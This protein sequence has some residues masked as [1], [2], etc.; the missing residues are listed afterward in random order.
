MKRR[1]NYQ[2][3]IFVGMFNFV[4]SSVIYDV[5]KGVIAGI[6]TTIGTVL[7]HLIFGDPLSDDKSPEPPEP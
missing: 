7:G 5:E 6:G 4:A 2:F 3:A 1:V